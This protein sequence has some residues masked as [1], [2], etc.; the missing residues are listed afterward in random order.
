MTTGTQQLPE[1]VLT[2]PPAGFRFDKTKEGWELVEDVGAVIGEPTLRLDEFLREGE[3]YVKGDA[4]LA[5]AKEMGGLA[6]Q[7]HA[8]R[9]LDQQDQISVEWRGKVLVFAGTVWRDPHGRLDVAYLS[10]YG[11]GWRLHFGWLAGVFDDSYRLVR[12][13]K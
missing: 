7:L 6:G 9:M 11:N 3:P 4:M 2:T 1:M 5:R 10:W 12:L 13:R 8:E